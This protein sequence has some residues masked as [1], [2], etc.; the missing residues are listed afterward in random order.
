MTALEICKRKWRRSSGKLPPFFPLERWENVSKTKDTTI[1]ILSIV[2]GKLTW[3]MARAP[4]GSTVS[5]AKWTPNSAR[6]KKRKEK[7]K[8]LVLVNVTFIPTQQNSS[9][10]LEQDIIPIEW[11]ICGKEKTIPKC[12]YSN[13]S[14]ALILPCAL[15]TNFIYFLSTLFLFLVGIKFCNAG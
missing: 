6:G 9:W 10:F 14:W 3:R 11:L 15:H 7:K 4:W 8:M 1:K 5:S 12:S 2:P 13:E